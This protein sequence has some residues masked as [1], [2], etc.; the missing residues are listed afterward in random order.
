MSGVLIHDRTADVP[1]SASELSG[2]GMEPRRGLPS[3][4]VT[5]LL[6]DVEGSTRLWDLSPAEMQGALET[7]DALFE[8]L[9]GSHG[10]V[11]VRPRGEGD[12]QFA[13]F[14]RAT[15]AVAAAAALELALAQTEWHLPSPLRMHVA[16]HSGEADLRAGD[17]YGG[18]VNRCA[19]LRSLAHGGQ[20][21]VSGATHDLVADSPTGWPPG[22]TVRLLGEHQ[23]TGLTRPERVFQLDIAGLPCDFPPLRAQRTVAHNLPASLSRFVGRE[24]ELA[25]LEHCLL[26]PAIRLITLTGPGGVGKTRLGVQAAAEVLDAFTDGAAFVSLSALD[27]A[28]LVGSAISAALSVRAI[29]GQN[30][31]EGLIEALRG[32]QYLLILDNFEH[33][34]QAAPLVAELLTVCPRLKVLT[35]S[36]EVLHLSGEHVFDVQPL[37]LPA[38]DQPLSEA[39]CAEA[40]QLFVDR[41]RAANGAFV[42]DDANASAV[43]EVCRRLDGLP[44]AIELA[45]ARVRVLSPEAILHRLPRRLDLLSGGPRD[46]PARQQTLR[47]A[48]AWSYDLLQPEDQE[49]LRRAGVFVGGWTVE[50]ASAVWAED[51]DEVSTLEGLQ[52]LVDRSLVRQEQQPDGEPRFVM[53]ETIRDFALEQLSSAELA[54]VSRGHADYFVGMAEQSEREL[55]SRRQAAWLERLSREQGNLRAALRWSFDSGQPQLG[56]RIAAAIWRF[57]ETHGDLS[58]GLGWLEQALA[59]PALDPQLRARSLA[60]AGSLARAR[61]ELE[62]AQTLHNESLRCYGAAD[63]ELGVARALSNLGVVAKEL[64]DY[65]RADTLYSRSLALRQKH[66][67]RWGV[68]V[69]QNNRGA[70]MRDMGKP[71]VARALYEESLSII[72]EL[73]DTVAL[74]ALLSNLGEYVQDEGDLERALALHE[75]SLQVCRH[76]GD[77]RGTARALVKL[78]SLAAIHHQWDRTLELCAEALRVINELHTRSLAPDCLE[79][80]AEAVCGLGQVELA[81]SL[82]GSAEATR[83]RTRTV[84]PALARDRHARLVAIVRE[85]LAP[86]VLTRAWQTGR[87]SSIETVVTNV[88]PDLAASVNAGAVQSL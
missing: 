29:A 81:A 51:P 32:R 62:R 27:R 17:Y 11:H 42:V 8:R 57:W 46:Q 55:T 69:V 19:R 80:M 60:A 63:D 79:L 77:K 61:G 50:G 36:R 86:E 47:A 76:L 24:H 75:E 34:L 7:C 52:R 87:T 70:L 13:V 44:L 20:L 28:D 83:E 59:C 5:F 58:E 3:G 4:T 9:V 37:G 74:A 38:A 25:R 43:I 35:T 71:S 65:A 45:A 1:G 56:A 15:D 6:A 21:L 54:A 48:I 88:R 31:S 18:A 12:S 41:A 73:G 85:L 67:D 64:G 33:V 22:T 26:D 10:G 68:A 14:Q 23:L 53:L 72:R 2:V 40:V 39:R 30:V 82:L 84:V 49:L 66:G 78:A 16:V